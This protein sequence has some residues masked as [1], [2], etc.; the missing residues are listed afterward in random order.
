EL[1]SILSVPLSRW[2]RHPTRRRI[3]VL[4]TGLLD[5][6]QAQRR[7]R[8]SRQTGH[9]VGRE[10]DVFVGPLGPTPRYQRETPQCRPTLGAAVKYQ[11]QEGQRQMLL[12]ARSHLTRELQSGLVAGRTGQL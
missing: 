12:G 2:L 8:T 6:S 5:R 3:A 1:P 11:Q 4:A 9:E 10:A 7:K